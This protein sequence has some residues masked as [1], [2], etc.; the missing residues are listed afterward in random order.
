MRRE[1]KSYRRIEHCRRYQRLHGRE[2]IV[3]VDGRVEEC[4]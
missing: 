1:K 4:H 3:E 2:K